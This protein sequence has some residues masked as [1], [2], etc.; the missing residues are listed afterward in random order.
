[1]TGI[2]YTDE[3]QRFIEHPSEVFLMACPGSGKT[4]AIIGRVQRLS[5]NIKPRKGIAVLSFTNTA[6]DEFKKRCQ[7]LNLKNVLVHPGYVGTFDAFVR[8]FFVMP[9]G[10]QGV[11]LRPTIVDSWQSIGIVVR[12]SGR[13]AFRGEGVP[14]DFF[15]EADGAIDPNV[16]GHAGLR[17]HVNA[18]KNNYE[19]AALAY[20][21][22]LHRKGILSSADARIVAFKNLSINGWSENLGAAIASR[23][24][25]II[26]DEAQ[27]CN[28]QDLAIIDWLREQGLPV[29]G[30]CDPDQAIY[31]FRRGN[32]ALDIFNE[33]SS[34]YDP[35][36]SLSLTGNFRS[37]PTI[38]SLAATLRERNVPDESVGE[39][40]N[41]QSDIHI[42][43]YSGPISD[44]IEKHFSSLINNSGITPDKSYIL[45]HKRNS[46]L[47]AVGV[48]ANGNFVGSSK[49]SIFAR[50][51]AKFWISK[52]N[53]QNKET[54]L[55]E[56]ERLI[57]QI[58]GLIED[59]EP[60]SSAIY[61]NE[62]DKRW[63][64]RLALECVTS[65]PQKCEDTNE[66]RAQWLS[67]LHKTFRNLGITYAGGVT[68]RRFFRRPP[69]NNWCQLLTN[70]EP[71][72]INCSTVH[73]AKGREYNAV[74]LV[75]PPNR[76]PVNHTEELISSWESGENNESKRV[77]YVAITRAHKMVA[78]AV[79]KAYRTRL[80]DI[81][82]TAEISWVLH[83]LDLIE[84]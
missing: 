23:F 14:L 72:I 78:I 71:S 29:T 21:Q 24:T 69:N 57:I 44:A 26:I 51:I 1:M 63:L 38:C 77:A 30:A 48:S 11:S 81:L 2:Q 61:T 41:V 22:N 50:A 15:D 45:S 35:Q 55:R 54:A 12:L 39:D 58:M 79:P 19:R 17:A 83:D 3:Q 27:D 47:K 84:Q 65:I 6:V 56:I 34:K 13:N 40:R 60:L 33:L 80:T 67:E 4:R 28:P 52:G 66:S 20:R 73:E 76:A 18:Q 32:E 8:H 16:I 70:E 82:D 25:E 36:N 37:N 7:N 68:E 62:I 74:C 53:D 10:I 42:M 75:I 43:E 9:S 64:R 49:V 5:V 31:G 46:A 59:N